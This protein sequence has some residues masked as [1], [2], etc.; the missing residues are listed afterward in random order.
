MADEQNPPERAKTAL[1]MADE[2]LAKIRD[3]AL[4][5]AGRHRSEVGYLDEPDAPL[6]DEQQLIA[7]ATLV[8]G[9]LDEGDWAHRFY[10]SYMTDARG[11]LSVAL[12]AAGVSRRVHANRLNDD[13]VYRDL[14]EE[15]NNEWADALEAELTR[16]NL[17][18]LQRPMLQ[19]GRIV[20]YVREFSDKLLMFQLERTRPDKWHLATM[21][22]RN[23]NAAPLAFKFAM[24]EAPLEIEEGEIVE[25]E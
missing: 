17:E 10:Q 3:D 11:T 21:A 9:L 24:S 1:E 4:E 7:P 20:T 6:E 5:I 23:A 16:R 15:A 25:Q 8:T 18:G 12:K 14:W 13:R 19:R 22:E 2:M